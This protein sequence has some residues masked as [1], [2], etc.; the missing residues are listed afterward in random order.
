MTIV[1]HDDVFPPGTHDAVWL[2]HVGRNGWVV[3][4]KDHRIRYRTGER[5]ALLRA[6]VRAFVLRSGNLTG[7][8]MAEAFL[9]ALPR[10]ERLLRDRAAPFIAGVWAEGRVALLVE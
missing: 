3:L 4:T 5:E 6:N 9:R 2:P 1:V 8:Q 7:Q 10:I